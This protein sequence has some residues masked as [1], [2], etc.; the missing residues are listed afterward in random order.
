M[1]KILFV[2]FALIF[3]SAGAQAVSLIP[4]IGVDIPSTMGYE[5][6]PDQDTKIG[7]NAA[8]EVRGA[9]SGYFSWGAGV[10]CN[11]PRGLANVGGDTDF[12]FIPVYV[13]LMFSPLKTWGEGDARP[14]F[15]ANVGYSEYAVSD[16][17]ENPAGGLYYGGGVGTEYKDFVMELT[18]SRYFGSYENPGTVNIDYM[19]I[20]VSIGYKLDLSK[21]SGDPEEPEE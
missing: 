9:I 15:K 2:C 10:E 11:F 21:N 20:S 1:K 7:Y 17:G 19:K 4:K 3:A 5:Y 16:I 13:S 14:Y 6:E 8:L 18:A 12:S